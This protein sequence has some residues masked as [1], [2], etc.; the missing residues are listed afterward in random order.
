MDM[1]SWAVMAALLLAGGYLCLQ[2]WR[3]WRRIKSGGCSS[4]CGCEVKPGEAK[5]PGLVQA[6]D[7]TAR[8]RTRV[9]NR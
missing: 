9:N 6:Q 2:M 1:Q 5:Q 8:L 3:G 4:S 7:L